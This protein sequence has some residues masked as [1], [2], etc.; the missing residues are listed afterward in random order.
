MIH[1]AIFWIHIKYKG[2]IFNLLYCYVK[3][4]HWNTYSRKV[5]AY[6]TKSY[7]SLE[8]LENTEGI[9]YNNIQLTSLNGPKSMFFH[10]KQKCSKKN[11][12]SKK[13]IYINDDKLLLILNYESAPPKKMYGDIFYTL[14]N[15]IQFHFVVAIS[16]HSLSYIRDTWMERPPENKV[17]MYIK[18][19]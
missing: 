16:W 10:L 14:L 1:N 19:E 6:P 18:I 12:Y 13:N 8:E 5:C 9:P 15:Y 4:N 7:K 2:L 3:L 17:S 11:F